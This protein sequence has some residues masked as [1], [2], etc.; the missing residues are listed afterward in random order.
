GLTKLEHYIRHGDGHWTP[1]AAK[2]SIAE[3]VDLVV[4]LREDAAL[5]RRVVEEILEVAGCENGEVINTNTL[6]R[7][8]SGEL[9]AAG[10]RPRRG[11][12][13][14]PLDRAHAGGRS[15][16]GHGTGLHRGR[17]GRP[18]PPS[19]P[20]GPRPGGR[21]PAQRG[22]KRPGPARGDRHGRRLRAAG[23]AR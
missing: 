18:P 9:V 20:G 6:W 10:I 15:R 8:R 11:V 5:R 12:R 4:H 23:A 2:E 3:N 7:R 21:P 13:L 14:H 22:A 1:Q 17:P 16:R 19:P